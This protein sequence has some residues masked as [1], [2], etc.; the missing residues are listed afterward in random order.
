MMNAKYVFGCLVGGGLLDLAVVAACSSQR[1]TATADPV[2]STTPPATIE[3]ALESCNK[4][5]QFQPPGPPPESGAAQP[6]AQTFWYAEHAYPGRTKENLAGRVKN[7]VKVADLPP[8]TPLAQK[9]EW[10]PQFQ[11]YIRD[12][13][14]AAPCGRPNQT[15][16]F[17]YT[18]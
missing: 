7:W 10:E 12:A 5:Y 17:V 3:V 13:M 18:P 9:Y 16:M 6:Q 8:L 15:T 14:V 4:S 2:G 1:S 11:V